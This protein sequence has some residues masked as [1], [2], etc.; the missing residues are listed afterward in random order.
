M[1]FQ[2][3]VNL[4]N[5]AFS[6]DRIILLKLLEK[7]NFY[8]CEILDAKKQFVTALFWIIMSLKP[9]RNSISRKYKT[10]PHLESFHTALMFPNNFLFIRYIALLFI[11]R[12]R[13]IST[14]AIS[15]CLFRLEVNH[16][17]VNVL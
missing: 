15:G 17:T 9:T 16:T 6:L 7:M 8:S 4:L 1:T 3:L 13:F 2:K 11:F 5:R 12:H 14:R 10:F